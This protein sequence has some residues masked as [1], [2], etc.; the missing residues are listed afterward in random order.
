MPILLTLYRFCSTKKN[1]CCLKQKCEKGKDYYSKPRCSSPDSLSNG[2]YYMVLLPGALLNY[3]C[4]LY[5]L[6]KYSFKRIIYL[7]E[8][9]TLP[10]TNHANFFAFTTGRKKS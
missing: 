9:L 10:E 1:P 5:I 4:Y 6:E 2:I 3:G 8:F 7:G